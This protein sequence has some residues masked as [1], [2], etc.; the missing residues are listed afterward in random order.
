MW[1]FSYILIT[2]RIIISLCFGDDQTQ[3]FYCPI[4]FPFS[5]FGSNLSEQTPQKNK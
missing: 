5:H 1:R 3:F 4:P 2:K